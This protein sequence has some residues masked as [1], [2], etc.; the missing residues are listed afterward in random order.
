MKH[1]PGSP[2]ERAS[3]K[4]EAVLAPPTH[5]QSTSKDKSKRLTSKSAATDGVPKLSFAVMVPSPP[6]RST[7]K[8][9]RELPERD[10]SSQLRHHITAVP[11]TF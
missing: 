7:Y 10:S 9:A 3:F 6:K 11:T 5:S 4:S 1:I 2:R 8:P